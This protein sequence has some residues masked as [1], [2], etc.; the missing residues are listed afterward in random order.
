M[1]RI[2]R[3]SDTNWPISIENYSRASDTIYIAIESDV[4]NSS[5]R[6][7]H[8]LNNEFMSSAKFFNNYQIEYWALIILTE[9]RQ[10]D[11]ITYDLQWLANLFSF[12]PRSG[13][14]IFLDLPYY[15]TIKKKSAT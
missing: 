4:C 5:L 11:R 9:A 6:Y 8:S 10:V 2:R 3:M 1:Y 7:M 13:L 15:K 14:F 12:P